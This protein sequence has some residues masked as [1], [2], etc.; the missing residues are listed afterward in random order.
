MEYDVSQFHFTQPRID[1]GFHN[2]EKQ[3]THQDH[4]MQPYGNLRT[5]HPYDIKKVMKGFNNT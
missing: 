3:L 1:S 5:P 4:H 2:F